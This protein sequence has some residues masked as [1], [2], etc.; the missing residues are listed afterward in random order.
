MQF[1]TVA[2]LALAALAAAAPA[3]EML[4]Q[5]QDFKETYGKTYTGNVEALRFKIFESNMNLINEHNALFAAGEK[6]YNLGM[7]QFG[8]LTRSVFC[9]LRSHYQ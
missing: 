4:A 5:F 2:V 1:V 9:C 7:N 8:D 6:S 3:S